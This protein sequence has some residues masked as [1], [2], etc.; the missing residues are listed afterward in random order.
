[1]HL[2]STD[3]VQMKR[4][5]LKPPLWVQGVSRCRLLA[6]DLSAWGPEVDPMSVHVG[7]AVNKTAMG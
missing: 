7:F 4:A 3:F 5:F 6:A 2:N 1:M